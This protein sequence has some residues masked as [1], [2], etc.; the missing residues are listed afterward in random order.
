MEL[1]TILLSGVLGLVS[2]VGL[3]LDRT[4][5]NAIRSQLKSAER[6]EVRIDNAPS[7]Q[8]LQGK[9]KRVR[10]AGRGLRLKQQDLRISALELETDPIN[11]DVRSLGKQPKLKRSFSAGVRLV[12][13]QQDINSALQSPAILARLRDLEISDLSGKDNSET[14]YNFVNPKVELLANNRLRFQVELT[15]DNN[16]TLAITVESGLTVVSGRQLQLVKPVVYVN[17]EAVT[18]Q[19]VSNIATNFHQKLDLRSLE[20]EGL[21]ARILQLNVSPQKLEIV[22]FLRLEPS[23]QFFQNLQASRN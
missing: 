10:I 23:S 17:Q 6:L 2:P 18:Q 22:A 5:E 21:K 13:E 9:V 8:I 7:Y 12:L 14:R 16:D 4:G 20:V 15:A 1:L 19:L 11:F 3:F